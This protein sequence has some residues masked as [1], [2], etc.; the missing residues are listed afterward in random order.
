MSSSSRTRR[1]PACCPRWPR[2]A[3]W[4]VPVPV[5]G[6][7]VV[8]RRP[9]RGAGRTTRARLPP[10]RTPQPNRGRLSRHRRE[11]IARLAGRT[12]GAARGGRRPRRRGLVGRAGAGTPRRPDPRS[13]RRG[14]RLVQQAVLGGPA[15]RVRSGPAAGRRSTGPGE[16]DARPRVLHRQPGDG[17]RAAGAPR[18]CPRPDPPE[19]RARRTRRAARRSARGALPAW[20]CTVPTGGLS[21]WVRLPVA[22]RRPVRRCRP[23]SRRRRG[24]GRGTLAHPAAHR[25]RLRLTFALPEPDL[26]AAVPRL[27]AAWAELRSSGSVRR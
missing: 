4:C 23:P 2:P 11:A 27:A 25:D 12:A 8:L 1:T 16:G 18:P 26:R 13:P 20:R 19:R 5:D 6:K 17:P 15:R 22:G 14:R 10:V 3:P 7:G 21:L 24:H 9:R